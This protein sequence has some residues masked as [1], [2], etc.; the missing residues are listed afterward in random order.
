[1]PFSTRDVLYL[2]PF[3]ERRAL[4]RAGGELGALATSGLDTVLSRKMGGCSAGGS[5]V[6]VKQI[7]FV[8]V[9]R[10]VLG[11]DLFG[12]SVLAHRRVASLG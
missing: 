1:M 7:S 12:P 3:V 5:L 8:L 2:S 6:L 9:L 11:L 10:L 4:R